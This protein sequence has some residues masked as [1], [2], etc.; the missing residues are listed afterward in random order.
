MSYFRHRLIYKMVSVFD[1]FRET[2]V[3]FK[4][5]S[6]MSDS[7]SYRPSRSIS[8]RTSRIP[9]NVRLNTPKQFDIFFCSVS[10]FDSVQDFFHPTC[11]LTTRRTL[12]A[13]FVVV[14]TRE[15][16]RISYDTRS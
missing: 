8:Y 10:G 5:F 3:I 2:N 9:L 7:G 6:E 4:F 16:P 14:E 11:S 13:T 15:I 12:S 1:F